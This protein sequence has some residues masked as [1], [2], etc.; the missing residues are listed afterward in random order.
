MKRLIVIIT[1]AALGFGSCGKD[2]A[3]APAEKAKYVKVTIPE[4]VAD[5]TRVGHDHDSNTTS[6]VAGD[7]IAVFL[8]DGATTH[9]CEFTADKSG[10]TTTFSGEVP[11]GM[12]N[13]TAAF[14][15]YSCSASFDAVNQ[16]F[17]NNWGSSFCTDK[18][19]EYDF[20]YSNCHI[21]Q[22]EVT[23]ET[24][25]LPVGLMF[26]PLMARVKMNLGLCDNETP[27]LVTITTSAAVMPTAGTVDAAGDFV[28]TATCNTLNVYTNEKEFIIGMLPVNISTTM[29]VSVTTTDGLTYSDKS[30]TLAGLKRNHHYTMSVPCLTKEM[31]LTV[32]SMIDSEYGTGKANQSL[33]SI[34]PEHDPDGYFT[35]WWLWNAE[36]KSASNGDDI[37]KANRIQLQVAGGS[38]EDKNGAVCTAPIRCDG[39][40]TAVLTFRTACNRLLARGELKVGILD[41]RTP[42]TADHMKS[43]SN[44]QHGWRQ[45]IRVNGNVDSYT[46]TLPINDGQRIGFKAMSTMGGYHIEI[47]D[48][49][50]VIQ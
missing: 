17:S 44:L 50:I 15:P 7:K 48:L 35:G 30:F 19:H 43:A 38:N 11:V 10:T 6:W 40:K 27:K 8:Y 32:P 22:V 33:K 34:S 45:D 18:L 46:V 29:N 2:Q 1:L 25:T 36:I 5:E 42:M 14:Y 3:T 37:I 47:A 9:K 23:E 31:V 24:T 39:T 16:S 41:D 21:D 12:Y 13:V 49:K 4:T 20:L 28:A 26:K